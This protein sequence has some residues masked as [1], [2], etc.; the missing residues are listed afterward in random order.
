MGRV[1]SRCSGD[2]LISV[3]TFELLFTTTG[4]SMKHYLYFPM[5][6]GPFMD[7]KIDY[8][9]TRLSDAELAEHLVRLRQQELAE[10]K[11]E[12][13]R[14]AKTRDFRFIGGML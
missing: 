5:P 13:E 10:A 14:R 8:E 7:Y 9:Y 4:G 12:R 6:A 2:C 11:A 3:T 1:S